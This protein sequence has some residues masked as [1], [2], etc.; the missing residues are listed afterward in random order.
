M[1]RAPSKFP[2]LKAR[3]DAAK[4]MPLTDR[5]VKLRE[6]MAGLPDYLANYQWVAAERHAFGEK[7]VHSYRDI[8]GEDGLGTGRQWI[9]TVPGDNLF[10]TLA[11]FIAA[12]N[13]DTIRMLLER[14]AVLEAALSEAKDFADASRLDPQANFPAISAIAEKGLAGITGATYVPPDTFDFDEAT[15]TVRVIPTHAK[16]TV[17][18]KTE[19]GWTAE[20]VVVVDAPP[21]APDYP[22]DTPGWMLSRDDFPFEWTDTKPVEID[23]TLVVQE[24]TYGQWKVAEQKAWDAAKADDTLGWAYTFGDENS[25]GASHEWSD[26]HPGADVRDVYQCTWREFAHNME[27]HWNHLD[28]RA[29]E[30]GDV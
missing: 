19:D 23:D 29:A 1:A 17:T 22:D 10:G 7:R 28:E 14:V 13:P 25:G 4:A 8:A 15:S 24:C 2:E 18:E 16:L 11:D 3:V 20:G 12:A 6:A 5:I 27:D 30:E 21:P 26:T 9:A